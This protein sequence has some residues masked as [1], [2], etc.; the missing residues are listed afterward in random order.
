MAKIKLDDA[1]KWL[2]ENDPLFFKKSKKHIEYPY[3]TPFQL[4][5]VYQKEK[6]FDDEILQKICS[7]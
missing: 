2:Y 6:S 7:K 5:D 3:L 4:K 1:E